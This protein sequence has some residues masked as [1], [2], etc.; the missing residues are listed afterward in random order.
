MQLVA[1]IVLIV[2]GLWLALLVD[3]A[4]DMRIFGWV[5]VGVGVL[6]LILRR[7]VAGQRDRLR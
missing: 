2:I 1:S 5:V 7:Y 3:K 4:G 6:G